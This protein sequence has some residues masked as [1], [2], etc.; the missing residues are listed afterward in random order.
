MMLRLKTT[1]KTIGNIDI[2]LSP[3]IDLNA[4][5]TYLESHITE[6]GETDLGAIDRILLGLRL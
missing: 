5:R 4:L 6:D 3:E 1:I 2:F